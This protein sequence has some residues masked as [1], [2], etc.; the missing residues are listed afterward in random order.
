MNRLKLKSLI[1][2]I[3]GLGIISAIMV[4]QFDLRYLW[5][6]SQSLQKAQELV[7][8]STALGEVV[9]RLQIERGTSAAYLSSADEVMRKVLDERR[10]DADAVIGPVMIELEKTLAVN[11]TKETITKLSTLIEHLKEL[12]K[13]RASV[14]AREVTVGEAVAFYTNINQELIIFSGNNLRYVDDGKLARSLVVYSSFLLAKDLA[15][16]ERATGSVILAGGEL[17]TAL[18]NRFRRLIASSNIMFDFSSSFADQVELGS[19]Q[20]ALTGDAAG[21]V[22]SMRETV[23]SPDPEIRKTVSSSHWFAAITVKIDNMKAAEDAFSAKIIEGIGQERAQANKDFYTRSGVLAIMILTLTLLSGVI[24]RFIAHSFQRV[25]TP[26]L[27]LAQGQTEFDLPKR[28]NNE[29]GQITK[30]LEVFRENT[31]ERS[32][33]EKAV[34]I[35]KDTSRRVLQE[36]ERGLEHLSSGELTIQLENEF[37][38][39]YEP[40]RK[41]FNTSVRKLDETLAKL[42]PSSYSVDDMSQKISAATKDLSQRTESQA[43]TLEQTS[44]A[45]DD[46]TSNVKVAARG[47][48]ETSKIAEKTCSDAEHSG[49][50]VREAVHSMKELQESAQSIANIT[51]VIEDIAFQTNLLALNAGVEAARAGEAGKGFAVV[52]S[53]VSALALRSSVAAKEINDLIENSTRQVEQGVAL[54]DKTGETLDG[55]IEQV[56]S[57][58]KLMTDLAKSTEHQAEGLN[59]INIGVNQIDQVTQRNAGMVLETMDAC[60]RLQEQA[61]LL[62]TGMESF[63]TSGSSSHPNRLVA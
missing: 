27:A 9:H 16:I 11:L 21:V 31:I 17:T 20:S 61:N 39:K 58:S 38:A 63:E 52:A 10:A 45:L 35:E 23:L 57:V 3:V 32:E 50:V 18:E 62:K 29:F 7:R 46:L 56:S 49:K 22:A 55:I 30:A 54:V 36:M 12:P 25:M 14:D 5:S 4:A 24:M 48:S 2:I 6:R 26:L 13:V 37:E 28:S 53:E 44:A 34:V 59:E 42:K 33:M 8:I 41:N 60:K 40:L 43:A 1:S 51:V 47:A 19:I 15:G